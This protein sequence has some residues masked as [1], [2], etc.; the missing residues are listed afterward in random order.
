MAAK[1]KGSASCT[2]QRG[3]PSVN[4]VPA[5]RSFKTNFSAPNAMKKVNAAAT[6]ELKNNAPLFHRPLRNCPAADRESSFPPLAAMAP[7]IIPTNRVRCW[8]MLLLAGCLC[9]AMGHGRLHLFLGQVLETA[10][11][12][13]STRSADDDICA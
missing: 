7:P 12:T 9:D 10:G 3:M 4:S 11:E 5:S 13:L 1:P 8:T 6:D 2:T